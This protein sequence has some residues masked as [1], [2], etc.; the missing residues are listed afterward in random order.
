MKIKNLTT[1]LIAATVLLIGVSS[2]EAK[3]YR[4]SGGGG[5]SSSFSSRSY[6]S[7]KSKSTKPS[8]SPTKKS[9]SGNKSSSKKNDT[10]K[11]TFK[12]AGDK[13]AYQKA[14][15]NGTA[16]KTKKEAQ[17]AFKK[18]NAKKYPSTYKTEPSKRPEHIPQTTKGPDGNTYNVNY[19]MNQGGYGYT[20]SLGTFIA[21]DAMTDLIVLNSLMSQNNYV[22]NSQHVPHTTQ[23]HHTSSGIG[24]IWGFVFIL[25]LLVGAFI[26]LR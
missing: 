22:V 1:A 7:S 8:S 9:Y 18:N 14:S 12:N 10:S 21:F 15:K 6:S 13:Q 26:I 17:T 2:I 5:K 4:S 3:S 20:N 16:F 11:R 24:F 25:L 19:N 23:V